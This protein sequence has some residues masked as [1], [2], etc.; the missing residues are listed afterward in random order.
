LAHA[1]KAEGKSAESK[2]NS[3]ELCTKCSEVEHL[4][5]MYNK[6]ER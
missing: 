5:E 6:R 4:R 3:L 2:K 1:E